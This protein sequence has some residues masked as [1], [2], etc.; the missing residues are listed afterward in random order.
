M[1][2]GSSI[3]SWED[4]RRLNKKENRG[5]GGFWVEGTYPLGRPHTAKVVTHVSPP[6]S[7]AGDGVH[8]DLLIR[9][10]HTLGVANDGAAFPE[11]VMRFTDDTGSSSMVINDTD[12]YNLMGNDA[13]LEMPAPM[14]HLMGYTYTILAD[15]SAVAHLVIAVEVSMEGTNPATGQIEEMVTPWT[16]ISCIVH[17]PTPYN[18]ASQQV[19]WSLATSNALRWI[20]ARVS[21]LFVCFH[22]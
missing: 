18:D 16:S 19:G 12:M 4:F 8:L 13:T 22:A 6:V 1:I 20:C 3:F 5:D 7:T 17:N 9:L 15:G 11:M 21:G 10:D 14:N 2:A